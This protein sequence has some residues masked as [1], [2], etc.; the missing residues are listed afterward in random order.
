LL[1]LNRDPAGNLLSLSAGGRRLD[2]EHDSLNRVTAISE[3]D[4]SRAM[5]FDYDAAGCLVR[6][7]GPDG[8]SR[9]DFDRRG[10]GCWLTRTTYDGVT[11]FQ[12][13]YSAEDRVVR[14]TNPA[15]GAYVI[16]YENDWRGRI[17]RA[18]VIDPEGTLRR[19]T[20]DPSSYWISRWGSYR[21]H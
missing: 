19:I 5:R 11:Y 7:T 10:G 14:L 2:F 17:V 12:A 15:G 20:V 9:Y 1:Q 18:E 4:A 8:E 3:P 21:K 13:D 6:Q 16:S